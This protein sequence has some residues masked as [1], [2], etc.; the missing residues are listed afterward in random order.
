MFALLSASF[1]SGVMSLT[2]FTSDTDEGRWQEAQSQSFEK[3]E[4]VAKYPHPSL[5]ATMKAA[6]KARSSPSPGLCLNASDSAVVA[7]CRIQ[8][9]ITR[10]PIGG[11]VYT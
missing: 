1:T 9:G 8:Q 2:K 10:I 3:S 4:F 6:K 11:N 7:S 5:I